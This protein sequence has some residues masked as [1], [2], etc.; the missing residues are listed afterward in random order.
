MKLSIIGAPAAS[1]TVVYLTLPGVGFIIF[2][3]YARAALCLAAAT[4]CAALVWF[5]MTRRHPRQA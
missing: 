2:G 5:V 3:L 1:M 4:A